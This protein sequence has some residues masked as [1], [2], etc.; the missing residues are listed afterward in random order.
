MPMT[1]VEVNGM[2]CGH[3]AAAVRQH[4]G[5]IPGVAAVE[6]DLETG[7]VAIASD[8]PLDVDVVEEAVA[9]AGYELVR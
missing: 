8:G 3:C 2:T 5:R 1:R 9:E 6:V 7:S 4:V